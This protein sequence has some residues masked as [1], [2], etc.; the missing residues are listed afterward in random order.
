[1]TTFSAVSIAVIAFLLGVYF[2]FRRE[3]ARMRIAPASR[4]QKEFGLYAENRPDIRLDPARVPADLR[5]LIPLAQKWGIGDDIIRNDLID[6]SSDAERRE[7]HDALYPVHER[8]TEWLSSIPAAELSEESA[9]FM[10]M[11][12]ALAEM[13][14]FLDDET[15]GPSTTELPGRAPPP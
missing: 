3:R 1:M 6:K 15:R 2:A 9:A 4:L 7:L 10:Y 8:V 11:E 5:Q 12:E 14:Y 13:G